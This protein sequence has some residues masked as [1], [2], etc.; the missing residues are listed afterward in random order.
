MRATAQPPTATARPRQRP[1]TAVRSQ[2]SC[3]RASS[4]GASGSS[5]ALCW[6]TQ[7]SISPATASRTRPRCGHTPCQA[8]PVQALHATRRTS[9]S[10]RAVSAVRPGP[11]AQVMVQD[12]ILSMSQ[13][14]LLT[15]LFPL[16]YGT[17]S[18]GADSRTARP[19][20]AART[21]RAPCNGPCPK[22]CNP[23]RTNLSPFVHAR[24]SASL[25]A[26]PAPTHAPQ[27]AWVFLHSFMHARRPSSLSG[28]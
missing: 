13:V 3:P 10:P 19:H 23:M 18:P 24:L 7:P 1:R 21:A 9:H 11:A 22:P 12:G 8:L 25:Q 4:R 26:A 14:G 16:T 15:S 5:P 27:P 28:W 6:A 17:V 2:R 20:T